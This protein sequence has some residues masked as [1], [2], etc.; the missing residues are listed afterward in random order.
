M[1]LI[2]RLKHRN[3]NLTSATEEGALGLP[4]DRPCRNCLETKETNPSLPM[5][6]IRDTSAP[7]ISEYTILYLEL[8]IQ[9]FRDANDT[10][11]VVICFFKS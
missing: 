4:G 7:M 11:V 1:T 2:K 6:F 10:H 8:C 9:T 5:I 3:K